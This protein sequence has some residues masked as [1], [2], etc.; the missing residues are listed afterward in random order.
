MA[1]STRDSSLAALTALHRAGRLDEAQVGYEAWLLEAP[2]SSLALAGLAAIHAQRGD[3]V[4]ALD[5]YA[6]ALKSNPA[7][8]DAHR[9][10]GIV[11]CKLG[12]LEE[13]IECLNRAIELKPDSFVA[14]NNRAV[15]LK[16][17]ERFDDAVADYDRAIAI[18]SE[19]L[20]AWKNRGITLRALNRLDECIASY[21]RALEIDPDDAQIWNYRG[22]VLRQQGR[23]ADSLASYQEAVRIRPDYAEAHY[24]Q[25]IVLREF[26][27][28]AE[29]IECCDRATALVPDYA[30]AWWNKAEMLVLTGDFENGWAMFEWRW[31]SDRH[32]KEFRD[33]GKPLW[34]GDGPLEGKRLLLNVDGGLGDVIQFCRYV[35]LLV[36]QGAQ[37]IVEAQEGLIPLLRESF[38]AIE[39]TPYLKP[40]PEFD[41]HCPQMSLPGAFRQ[42]VDQ[43]TADLPYLRAPA[44]LREAW[45]AKLGP[46]TRPRIGLV[47]S[48][49]NLH[50]KGQEH[51][52]IPL[53]QMKSL[54]TNDAE[55][56]CLQKEILESDR[57]AL[58]SLPIQTWEAELHDFA[59]TA[60]LIAQMDLVISVDTAVG[61]LTGAMGQQV[62]IILPFDPDMRWMLNRTD[63]PWYP[64][65]MHLF[66]QPSLGDWATPLARVREEMLRWI[67]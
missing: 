42:S 57:A 19:Y 16:A 25:S 17:L 43:L 31:K 26:G 3:F 32:G 28:H 50:Y 2:A 60:A 34:L 24:N 40:L 10:K 29:A 54:L 39:L 4:K 5:H 67:G 59:E 7:N 9:Q 27:R 45:A 35:P 13:A 49:G 8:A 18:N 14:Y 37:V 64:D 23:L 52:S 30:D 53:E 38:D 33:V 44:L 6:R 46:K 15:V 51:R 63:T 41:C 11:L 47:W 12:R 58:A 20:S 1:D 62:W 21:D 65:V 48:G 36:R 61:H 66:R 22:H 55:F 56:H